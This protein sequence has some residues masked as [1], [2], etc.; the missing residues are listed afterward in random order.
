MQFSPRP[1]TDASSNLTD[2]LLSRG[3]GPTAVHDAEVGDDRRWQPD[4]VDAGAAQAS[5]PQAAAGGELRDSVVVSSAESCARSPPP[6]SQA[7]SKRITVTRR[8]LL[9]ASGEGA[10]RDGLVG[11]RSEGCG[12]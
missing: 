6:P 7:E 1:V 10:A 2:H 3:L 9:R 5:K 4:P 12:L 11:T 8:R